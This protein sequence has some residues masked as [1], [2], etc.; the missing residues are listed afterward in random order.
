MHISKNNPIM[1]KLFLTACLVMASVITAHAQVQPN[2]YVTPTTITLGESTTFIRDGS[3]PAGFAWSEATLWRPDGGYIVL[4][5]VYTTPSSQAI[6]PDAPGTYSIQYRL[7]DVNYDYQDQ[8]IT[9]TVLSPSNTGGGSGGDGGG[10][11][12]G[13]QL[14]QN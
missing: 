8:W 5:H 2:G 10:D 14:R 12:G 7:V 6:T 1:K 3:T 9:F 11:G 13:V 4:G